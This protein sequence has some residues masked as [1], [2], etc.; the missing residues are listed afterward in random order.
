M[1]VSTKAFYI[2]LFRKLG[3]NCFAIPIRSDDTPNQDKKAGDYR[4]NAEKTEHGQV[5]KET[6]NYGVLPTKEG[7]NAW[8]DF[9]DKE[10]YRQFATIMIKDGYIVIETP[11]GW[12]IPVINLSTTASKKNL[13]NYSIR[14]KATIEIQGT[15]SYVVG[16]GSKIVDSETKEILE[17]KSIGGQRIW[18]FKGK[19]FVDFVDY[20]CKTCNVV[21]KKKST[22]SHYQ[23]LRNKFN[24]GKLPTKGQSNDYF[25][26]GAVVL[27][28]KGRTLEDCLSELEIVFNEW[29]ESKNY[30]GRLW[31]EQIK[32]I[33]EVYENKDKYSLGSGRKKGS[34][35]FDREGVAD[36]VLKNKTLYSVKEKDGDVF[37]NRNGFL[38]RINDTLSVELKKK[39]RNMSEMDYRGIIFSLR[40]LSPDIPKTNKNQIRFPNG[41]FD[42]TMRKIIET[43]DI[44]DMGF[45]QYNY[46]EKTKKNEPKEFLKF[47]KDYDKSE[48]PRIKMALRSILSGHKDFRITWFYG[49]SNVGKSL[50]LTIVSRILGNEYALQV[51]WKLFFSDR[52]TQALSNDKRLVVFLDVP[53]EEINVADMKGKTGESQQ[54]VRDFGK[55]GKQHENKVKYFATT[56]K[57]PV[58]KEDD[59]NAMFTNRLSLCHNT[60]D[61]PYPFDP[62]MEDRI[63]ENEA[64][65]ILSYILNFTDEECAYEEQDVI[66]KEWEAL[67]EPELSWIETNYTESD[68]ES[69][70]KSVRQM[71]RE[72]NET[73][74]YKRNPKGFTTSI[75]KLGYSEF[76]G[77]VKFIKIKPKPVSI[78][79]NE[80]TQQVATFKTTDNY[81]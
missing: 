5:I 3:F 63:T 40:N 11:H 37:E 29:K 46:L 1:T 21:D 39:Y 22:T 59:K 61:K 18:D 77:V 23:H 25:M 45:N 31:S 35:D 72:F 75:K 8:V 33:E 74:D 57:L 49:I 41:S 4:Y 64:E 54:L 38:E 2:D 66:Q 19:P 68:D 34:G 62:N 80:K 12:H 6:E 58:V 76:N 24:E 78:S 50:I 56:N 13:H 69:D 67:S 60:R 20:I 42:I 14:D 48:L 28:D 73:V 27:L 65:K 81:D 17:Y 30:T 79:I 55:A 26:Q 71:L 53:D 51:D 9:D 43:D 44:A 36:F 52:A 15:K 16:C 47:F 70:K 7:K 32:K 10:E